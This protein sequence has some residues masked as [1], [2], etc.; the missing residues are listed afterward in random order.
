MKKDTYQVFLLSC[1]CTFPVNF[2]HH[3]WFVLNEK[4]KL[5]RWE[6]LLDKECCGQKGHVYKDA[7][8]P[9]KSFGLFVK[10]EKA[11]FAP[12]LLGLMEGDADSE[13]FKMIRFIEASKETYPYRDH[14]KLLGPNSNTYVKWV[15]DQFP[16]FKVSTH[17]RALGAGFKV[18]V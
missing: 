14:Y 4:G 13:A 1:P 7:Q 18:K 3:M 9:F 6:V 10:N 15:L 8:A 2:A 5:S 17:W 12:T 16:G 11:Y